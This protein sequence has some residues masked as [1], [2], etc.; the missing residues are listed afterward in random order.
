MSA[1]RTLR[2]TSEKW[3]RPQHFRT[4]CD[5]FP[6]RSSSLEKH[7]VRAAVVDTLCTFLSLPQAC[8][9]AAVLGFLHTLLRI[10]IVF[11]YQFHYI[12]LIVAICDF[13]IFQVPL[14]FG[15]GLRKSALLQPFI[16][17]TVCKLLLL[18]IIAPFRGVLWMSF[19]LTD[20]DF[21]SIDDFLAQILP[22]VLLAVI[23]Q[24][25]LLGVLLAVV[26]HAKEMI[27]RK[28]RM[29]ESLNKTRPTRTQTPRHVTAIPMS[30]L[31]CEYPILKIERDYV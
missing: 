8:V 11:E 3:S 22:D 13:L 5:A 25:I 24:L 1:S 2:F 29:E 7:P 6:I 20:P 21:K 12:G 4:G 16:C 27:T 15:V 28:K 30:N 18:L 10:A 19:D 26:L 17:E 9:I 31:M 14:F 23:G